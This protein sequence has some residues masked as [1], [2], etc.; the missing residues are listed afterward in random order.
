ME[1]I[2]KVFLAILKF[3]IMPFRLWFLKEDSDTQDVSSSQSTIDD[4]P[5]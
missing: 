1:K 3:V 4:N 5:K 2:F